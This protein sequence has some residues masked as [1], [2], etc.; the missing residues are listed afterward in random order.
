RSIHIMNQN[1][2]IIG[3]GNLGA[4]IAEG[5]L[6]SNYVQPHQLM[7]TRRNLEALKSLSN[8]GVIVTSDNKAA[9]AFADVVIVAIKPFQMQDV[10]GQL[11]DSLTPQHVVVSVVT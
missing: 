4:S 7:V 9:L 6:K 2:A 5:L 3:G 10:L 11:R 8:R 1:I